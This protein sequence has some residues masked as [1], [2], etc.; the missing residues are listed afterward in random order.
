MSQIH[1]SILLASILKWKMY[2]KTDLLEGH[3]TMIIEVLGLGPY[4]WYPTTFV[5]KLQ[6]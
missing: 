4:G 5:G 1:V 2:W 6:G 3:V